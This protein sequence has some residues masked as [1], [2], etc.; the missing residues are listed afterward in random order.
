MLQLFATAYFASN[1][2]FRH[3][4]AASKTLKTLQLCDT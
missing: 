4:F 1:P 3:I 2:L